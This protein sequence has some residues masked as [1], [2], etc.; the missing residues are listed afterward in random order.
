MHGR[1]SVCQGH[2]A[3]RLH[4]VRYVPAYPQ[5]GIDF[6]G[7]NDSSAVDASRKREE[8]SY[9]PEYQAVTVLSPEGGGWAR[10]SGRVSV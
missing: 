9:D 8:A 7:R 10:P 6:R 5:S 1:Q 3:G 2:G 4:D